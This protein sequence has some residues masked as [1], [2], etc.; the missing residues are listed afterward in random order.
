MSER[1]DPF[2][3]LADFSPKG[4]K[5]AE[6]AE[7]AQNVG[8]NLGFHSRPQVKALPSRRRFTGRDQQLNMKV[9]ME[10]KRQ[11]LE[12]SVANNAPLGAVLEKALAALEKVGWDNVP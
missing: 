10:T 11:F 5:R 2:G 4:D 3:D 6:L 8:E 7:V 9:T 12:I 1:I